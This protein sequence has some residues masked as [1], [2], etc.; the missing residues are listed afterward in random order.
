M[1][2]FRVVQEVF[3][4]HVSKMVLNYTKSMTGHLLGAGPAV[5]SIAILMSMRDGLVHPTI[6]LDNLDPKI[7]QDWNFA[8][9]G[10]VKCAINAAISNSFG[11]GGHNVTLL[12]KKY[13]Q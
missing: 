8:A 2:S 4:S 10:P 3:G 1:I 13:H 9:H 12:Y 11:F 5:E 6:N 7:P